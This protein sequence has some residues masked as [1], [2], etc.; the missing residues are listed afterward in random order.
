MSCISDGLIWQSYDEML[1]GHVECLM[2]VLQ[3][4]IFEDADVADGDC[5]FMFDICLDVVNV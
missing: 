3:I 2:T 4:S 5:M 1:V